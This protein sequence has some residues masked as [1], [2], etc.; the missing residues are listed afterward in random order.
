MRTERSNFAGVV[1]WIDGGVVK[2][3]LKAGNDVET[4][5]ETITFLSR[6]AFLREYF[7]LC[8]KCYD[9]RISMKIKWR[10]RVRVERTDDIR[11]A[12]RRF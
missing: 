4:R 7:S 12:V 2:E 5:G 1:E 10:K 8:D 9:T 3:A 6:Q 11:D